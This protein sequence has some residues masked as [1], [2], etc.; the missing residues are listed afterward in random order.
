MSTE[1]GFT[2]FIIGSF[3][4]CARER[5]LNMVSQLGNHLESDKGDSKRIVYD[6]AAIYR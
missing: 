2:Q 1:L 4:I 6:V 5:G 3:H